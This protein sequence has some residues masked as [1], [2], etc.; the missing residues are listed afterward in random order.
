MGALGRVERA[1]LAVVDDRGGRPVALR[2]Q[3]PWKERVKQKERVDP[4][5][6]FYMRRRRAHRLAAA[7]GDEKGEHRGVPG[8]Q[9]AGLQEA[10]R[11]VPIGRSA[12]PGRPADAASTAWRLVTITTETSG[13]PQ[14]GGGCVI[15]C[16][17]SGGRSAAVPARCGGSP[18]GHSAAGRHAVRS[19]RVVS[20][21]IPA[22]VPRTLRMGSPG[23][24]ARPGE[25]ASRS[26][27]S[28]DTRLQNPRDSAISRSVGACMSRS[29][30]SSA[31]S[32]GQAIATSGSS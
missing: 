20:C 5:A 27:G 3:R 4:A 9:D 15:C 6:Q 8:E 19:S 10:F 7:P 13:A 2:P 14:A 29:E 32:R 1:H 21:A 25:G 12:R 30:T 16:G 18:C 24:H 22:R 23:A 28:L 17:P 26:G 11:F 31:T